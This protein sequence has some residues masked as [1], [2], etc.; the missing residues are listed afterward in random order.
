M[1]SARDRAH[2]PGAGEFEASNARVADAPPGRA[3]RCGSTRSPCPCGLRRAMPRPTGGCGRSNCIASAWWCGARSPACAWRSTCRCRPSPA[4][5][6][7]APSARRP[8]TLAVVLAHKTIP[9]SRCRCYRLG[10]SR[11]GFAPNGRPGAPCSACRCWSTTRATAG[12]SLFARSAVFASSGRA[13]AP[14]PPQRVCKRRPS[15]LLR[16]A[17][18]RLTGNAPV[19][20]GEREIIARN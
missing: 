17:P 2:K 4:S 12:A 6:S 19:H 14:P 18:R 13:P 16:R 15:I 9:R 1:I 11:R 8:A 7:A 3:A 20:R 5:R 10:R